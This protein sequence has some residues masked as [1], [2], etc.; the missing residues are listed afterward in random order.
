MNTPKILKIIRLHIVIGGF[1]AFLVGALLALAGN[2]TL[3]FSK[4]ILG[5]IVVFLADLSTHFGNDYFDV[6]VDKHVISKKSFSGSNILV[7]NPDLR[8]LSKSI[9]I[10]LLLGSNFLAIMSV[11]F[12][13]LSIEFFMIIL[14]ASLIG[15][16]YSAPPIRLVSRGL[17]EFAVAFVTGFAI[18]SLGYLSIKGQLDLM[19]IVLTI[20][21]MMYGLALSLS[22]HIPDIEFDKKGYKK[23]LTVRLG[24]RKII[25][26]ILTLMILATLAFGIISF[27]NISTINFTIFAL[28]SIVPLITAVIGFVEFSRNKEVNYISTLNIIALFFFNILVIVFL[29]VQIIEK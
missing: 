5:Y 17:G 4:F 13:G 12:V 24:Q 28:F 9:S 3:V 22:L 21:F 1:L 27:L 8:I 10:V 2:A 26:L 18:P 6:E 25:F 20:P 15:W 19:L 7:Y 29:L 16:F 14:G 11:F 23:N